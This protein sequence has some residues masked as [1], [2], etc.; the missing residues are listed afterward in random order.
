MELNRFVLSHLARHSCTFSFWP[1]VR[2][3]ATFGYFIVITRLTLSLAKDGYCSILWFVC[4]T[5]R[6]FVDHSG[7]WQLATRYRDR[8]TD[9][10]SSRSPAAQEAKQSTLGG[11]WFGTQSILSTFVR[12]DKR[13]SVDRKCQP[14]HLWL[15]AWGFTWC[16]SGMRGKHP[17]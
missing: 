10:G 3:I 1:S 11:I 4:S 12:I 2:L 14:G 5:R 17:A 13:V 7:A 9:D 6:Q 16:L 15:N 8:L